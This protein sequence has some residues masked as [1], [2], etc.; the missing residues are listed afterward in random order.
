MGTRQSNTR[1][2]TE[3]RPTTDRKPPVTPE[4]KYLKG[5]IKECALDGHPELVVLYGLM[6]D[7]HK[8]AIDHGWWKKKRSF[9][10]L[11]SLAHSELSEAFEGVRNNRGIQASYTS[12]GGKP[13]GVGSE[14]ADTVIRIFDTCAKLNIDLPAE[15]IRKMEYN[16]KRPY[17][18]G[19]KAL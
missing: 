11:I 19:G 9:G 4:L 10:D 1:P 5:R 18:H 15:I 3:P 2:K 12:E 7:V 13:E 14:L 16:A 8:T 17:R 6:Y